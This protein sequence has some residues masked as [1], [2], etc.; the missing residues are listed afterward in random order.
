MFSIRIGAIGAATFVTLIGVAT[1]VRGQ[2]S[3][4]PDDARVQLGP[5]ALSPAIRLTNFGVDNN[6][7]HESENPTS[8]TTATVSPVLE[9][10]LGLPLVRMTGRSEVD[11]VYY[12]E[13]SHLRSLDT[14]NSARV[15]LLLRR[16]TPHV[17]GRTA[18]TRHRRNL[19]I[20]APVRRLEEAAVV[21]AELRLTEKVSIDAMATRSR[22]AYDGDT[23][24]LDS[25]LALALNRTATGEGVTVRYTLTPFTTVGLHAE[26][27]RDRFDFT[28]ARDSDSFRIMPVVEFKPLA[29]VS[30]RA[31]VGLR[32][33]TFLDGQ[34]SEFRGIAALVDLRYTLLGRTRF[35][36]SAQRD[37]AYSYRLAQ[38]EYLLTGV[39]LAV[40]QRLAVAWDVRA[41]VGRSRLTY[42]VEDSAG[43]AVIATDSPA[44]T[45]LSY[46]VDVGYSV[47]TARLGM[48]VSRQE[49]QSALSPR[50]EYE[51]LRLA[52]SVT[53]GF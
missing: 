51:R 11:L 31:Q 44:E 1:P 40:T 20:D 15:E 41:N 12:N 52:S 17:A 35:D 32:R 10:W 7:F 26:R 19:E 18:S 22:V 3:G 28:P 37:L 16:L 43:I 49:R 38:Q 53:Y 45:V 25:D 29:L 50:R 14:D 30:G 5:L 21:G 39:N 46:G 2:S 27:Q 23:V 33:R 36:I 24:Y 4:E 9:A 6:V 34:T 42:R 48:Q 13:L 47:G 8:D